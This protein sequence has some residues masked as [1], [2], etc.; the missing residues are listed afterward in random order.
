MNRKGSEMKK[1]EDE[2]KED[3][4]VEKGSPGGFRTWATR[5]MSSVKI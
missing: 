1:R 2:R 5:D 4:K 3:G